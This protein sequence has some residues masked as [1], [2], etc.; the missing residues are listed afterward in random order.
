[1]T[2][3][4]IVKYASG[5]TTCVTAADDA[6]AQAIL[7]ALV[8]ALVD[9]T[10]VRGQEGVINPRHVE[11]AYAEGLTTLASGPVADAPPPVPPAPAAPTPHS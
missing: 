3:N 4:V 1:M 7:D 6:E 8:Q 9:G 10:C 5:G 2:T 11:C